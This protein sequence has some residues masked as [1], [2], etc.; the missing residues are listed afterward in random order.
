MKKLFILYTVLSLCAMGCKKKMESNTVDYEFTVNT[1]KYIGTSTLKLTTISDSRCPINANCIRM[2]EAKAYFS[3]TSNNTVQD[4]TL[5]QGECGALGN[6]ADVTINGARYSLKLI[7][8]L[9]YPQ[10][11]QKEN[12]KTAKVQLTKI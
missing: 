6:T 9:P 7:D 2:G 8:V 5:C 4:I 1:S 10:G 3:I 12:T 11:L